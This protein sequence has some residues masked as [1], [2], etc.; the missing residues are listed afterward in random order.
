[1]RITA[2]ACAFLLAAAGCGNAIDENAPTVDSA[3]DEITIAA[4]QK[5]Y[6]FLADDALEGRMTG[7]PGYDEA[8]AYVADQLSSF[9]VEPAGE[10]GWYQP[11][12]LIAY[13]LDPDDPTVIVH[14]DGGDV[15]L[16]FRDDYVMGG[17]IVRDATSVRAE[18]VYVGYGVH[19]PELGYS[20][21]DDIDVDGKISALLGG[22][23]GTFPHNER[24]YYA[25][26]RTKFEEAAA[27]GAVGAV[28]LRSR[29][30]V[31]NVPWDRVKKQVGIRPGMAWVSATGDAADYVPQIEAAA[32]LNDEAAHDFFRATPISFTEALEA[33]AD[34]RPAS[35]PLG[36]EVTL[37]QAST[38][39]SITSPNVVGVVRGTDPA[40]ADEFVVY[41]AHLDHLGR[42]VAENGDDIYN[43]AYDNAMGIALMLETA[44]AFALKPPRRSVLFVA[45]T[46]EERGLLGSDYFAHYPTVPRDA[47]VANVNLDMP[48]FLYPLADLIAFGSE[49]STLEHIVDEAARAE[50]FELTPDPMPEETLFIRSDQYSFVRKGIP[51]IFLVPGNAST[52]PDVDGAARF[53]DFILNHYHR[54]SDD[55]S[56]PV[57]WESARRFARAN[58][59]IGTIVGNDDGRPQWNDGDFFGERFGDRR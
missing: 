55:L 16:D 22:A 3:L 9:G 38:R 26:S 53:R 32:L 35:V 24:A 4:L 12:P 39:K 13:R 57:D 52:D 14:R 58:M 40:L 27:R 45:V 46:A 50:G 47:I 19:A 20:D 51:S 34:S 17:D 29:R 54:P 41:S 5:H 37:S 11:V 33:A 2:A 56:R 21:Y 44:R 15:A 49:H 43:G 23:P 10:D 7:Q 18:V 59:R 36:F 6:A 8:A 42:G 25:S 48:L 30:S 1:M 31:K 28:V